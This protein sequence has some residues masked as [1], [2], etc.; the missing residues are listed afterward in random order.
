MNPVATHLHGFRPQPSVSFSAVV[1]Q[2]AMKLA[3]LLAV[4]D[5]RLS[6]VLLRGQSGTAKSSLVRALASIMPSQLQVTGCPYGC[7]PEGPDQ[8][9]DCHRAAIE[10]VIS[11]S[12]AAV[13]VVELPL[14]ASEDQVVGSLDFEAALANQRLQFKPGL[15]ARANRNLMFVDEVNLLGDHLVDVLLDVAATGVNVVE[16]EGFSVR[17]PARFVLVGTM[18]PAEGELRPQLLDR[19]GLCVDV[20]SVQ[21]ISSRVRIMELDRSAEAEQADRALSARL[22]QARLWLPQVRVPDQV[23]RE[24]VAM[25]LEHQV[26][27]HRADIMLVR[28]ARARRAWRQSA[29]AWLD[30]PCQVNSEDLLEVAELV[31]NHRQR[32][33]GADQASHRR[34]DEHGRVR[35]DSASSRPPSQSSPP[36][37]SARPPGDGSSASTLGGDGRASGQGVAAEDSNADPPRAPA[38]AIREM[39]SGLA[40]Q[41]RLGRQRPRRHGK[42][43][44]GETSARDSRG[45]YISARTARAPRDLALDATLRAAAP[46]QGERR[47]R[48][49]VGAAPAVQLEPWDLRE[50]VRQRKVGTLIVFVVDASASMDTEQR[51][52]AARSAILALLRAAYV[53]RDRVAM[54][55]FAGRAARVVLSPTRSV[56]L[57]ERQL[58]G[59]ATGGATPLAEGLAVSL[60]L[61]RRERRLD[62]EI[63]PLLVFISDGRGNVG[64]GGESPAEAARSVA[65]QVGHDRIRAVVLDS[66]PEHRRSGA[67]ISG[68]RIGHFSRPAAGRM[69]LCRELAQEMGARYCG[70]WDLSGQ[71]VLAPVAEVLTARG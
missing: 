17:H 32:P 48:A 54:V 38:A 41:M 66:S 61:I 68:Q 7:P 42:G 25:A 53:R 37:S 63:L 45:R 14:G 15:L 46:Y 13:R 70:L 33:R 59:L 55:T 26:A 51:M 40:A 52:D 71:A 44:S 28:A 35:E 50:K 10:G 16:R 8:C 64:W 34:T 57:A 67:V 36:P 24:A 65:A 22:G 12:P 2:E 39:E 5:R 69:G 29:E 60:Q 1:G 3:L 11:T 27:G 19:F 47:R 31:L 9:A 30:E 4:V 21:D 23:V 49:G 43:R 6:G 58:R 20:A 18:N 62:P 56:Q